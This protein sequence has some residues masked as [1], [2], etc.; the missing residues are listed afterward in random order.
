M[1]GLDDL[2]GLLQ[3]SQFRDSTKKPLGVENIL[4]SLFSLIFGY[5]E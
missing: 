3:P 1:L 4:N 2:K 5:F